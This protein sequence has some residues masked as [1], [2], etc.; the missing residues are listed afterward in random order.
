MPR[1]DAA[2][3]LLHVVADIVGR[4]AEAMRLRHRL[5]VIAFGSTA[6]VDLPLAVI[7][8]EALPR[9]H[10]R[11]DAIPPRVLGQTDVLAALA[12]AAAI[13]RALP[14]EAVRRRAIVVLTDGVPF[15]RGANMDDYRREL[16][17]FAAAQFRGG[18]P[19]VDVLLLDSAAAQRHAALWRAL[20][21][22]RVHMVAGDRASLLE[23]V[24][25]V[26]TQLVGT[27]TAESLPSKANERL[28][29]LVV[30]PYLD[31]IVLD[32]FHA[33]AAAR[34]EVFPPGA[35]R[36][37]RGGDGGVESVE[38]GNVLSTLI[39]HRPLPGSWIVRKASADAR[40][41][42]L[43]QQFF[44][45]GLLLRPAVSD[46]LRQ[47]DRVRIAYGIVDPNGHPLEELPRYKLAINLA[48]AKPDGSIEPV[49]ME[50][51]PEPAGIAFAAVRE[52]ECALPGRYWTTVGVTS[53]D[54]AGNRVDV[55][56]DRWSGFTVD[57][58]TRIDCH[59]TAAEQRWRRGV[60][61]R[62]DCVDGDQ[63]PVEMGGLVNGSPARLFRP[64]LLHGNAQIEA[65]LDL[66][67][68]GRGAFR[69]LLRGAER[70]GS[71]R[72]QLVVDRSRLRPSYNVRF[73]PDVVAFVRHPLVD[74]R[75]LAG[76]T[77]VAAVAAAA[78]KQ[79]LRR[80]VVNGG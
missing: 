19:T 7:E 48:L 33:A 10:Q 42:I 61:A 46:A 11:I 17:R 67:Y 5:G 52:S 34:V 62:V 71:Y 51:R 20:S 69:G 2:A 38:L 28:D 18:A 41:R 24:H 80:R 16:Q 32:I 56:H 12:A 36:P 15:V 65:T 3:L 22:D 30:P 63:Q 50:R 4:N 8:R 68:L 9:L 57:P 44:P 78:G 43:A 25:R 59:V 58:A 70:S 75:L 35:Q 13:F 60:T 73:V 74:L 26:T 45:R 72:L 76:L 47:H 49:A 27:A 39:V 14:A 64:R 54:A 23:E 29:V 79:S 6:A 77:F 37:L 55:F 40:V 66:Q 31:V 53:I 1:G 21:F